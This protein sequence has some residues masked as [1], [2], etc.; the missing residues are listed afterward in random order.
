VYKNEI[1]DSV[2][3]YELAIMGRGGFK[4]TISF[5]II[6]KFGVEDGKSYDKEVIPIISSVNAIFEIDGKP[7]TP[8]DKI[9]IVGHHTLTVI[10]NSG[11]DVN[12]DFTIIEEANIQNDSVHHQKV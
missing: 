12:I 5:K 1:I 10:G 6:P 11:Y 9:D 4:Q 3:N 8:G 7:Y 2:G